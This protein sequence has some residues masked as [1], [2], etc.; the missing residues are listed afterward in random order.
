[1]GRRPGHDST[2]QDIL[3]SAIQVFAERG[4]EGASLRMIT[5]R[6][7]VDVSLVRHFFGGK[8][9]LFDQAILAQADASTALLTEAAQ[10]DSSPA[11]RLADS[12]LTLWEAPATGPTFQALFRAA[13]ESPRNRDKLQEVMTTHL[14]DFVR[15]SDWNRDSSSVAD[16][17][18]RIQ[19]LAAH[20]M[21]IGVARYI[22]KFSPL[23]DLPREQVLADLVATIER[24]LPVVPRDGATSTESIDPTGPVAS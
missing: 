5:S 22:L 21:G 8:E 19:L 4:Y 16:I 18:S 9:G 12:Y 6:A 14:V 17:L 2:R 15:T 10:G 20:L 13:L 24:Y 11:T 23:A 3:D 7:G 1:M